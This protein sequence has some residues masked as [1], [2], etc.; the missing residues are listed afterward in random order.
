MMSAMTAM[1]RL[2]GAVW[3]LAVGGLALVIWRVARLAAGESGERALEIL[4]E[5]YAR[6]EISRDEFESRR[7]DL[8]A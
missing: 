7:R 5:R 6:G 4:R 1:V 8:A 2:V 3:V